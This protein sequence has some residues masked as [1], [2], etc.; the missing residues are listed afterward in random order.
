MPRPYLLSDS[1]KMFIAIVTTVD[2][3]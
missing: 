2:Q 3:N 1:L